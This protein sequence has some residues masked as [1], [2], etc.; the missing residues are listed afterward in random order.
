MEYD[1]TRVGRKCIECECNFLSRFPWQRC[2]SCRKT[3]RASLRYEIY[4]KHIPVHLRPQVARILVGN[5][6]VIG[7]VVAAAL[8]F[9]L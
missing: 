8:L 7:V 2:L 5:E 3:L 9:L 6:W 4:L 1:V